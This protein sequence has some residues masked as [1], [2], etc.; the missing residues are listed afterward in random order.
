MTL[1]DHRTVTGVAVEPAIAHDYPLIADFLATTPGLAGRKFAA[2]SRDVAEQFDGVYPGSVVVVRGES[3]DVLGYAALHRPDGAE[4]EVLGDFVFGPSV[5]SATV[6]SVVGET[7]ER[8]HRVT[9][10]DAY[11]RVYV[12]ADQPAAIEALKRCGARLERQFIATRKPLLGEDPAALTAAHLDGL[13]IL[14]WP[15]VVSGGLTEQVRQLQF[16]TF[17]EHFGNM[18]K[19]P[20]RWEHHL[21]SRVFNPDFSIAAVDDGGVVVGYVLGSTYT[22]GTGADEER[23]AHTDYIGVRRDLRA[24]GTGELLLR[25]VWLAAL[26]RGFTVASLGTDIDN[27]SKAHELYRRLGYLAVRDQYAYRIDHDGSI[28]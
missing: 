16:D 27:A 14:S 15:E 22:E 9:G 19:T 28:R 12:G 20:K 21:R 4:P 6:E 7:V 2:D 11:L 17:S 25:K 3:A 13:T 10:P 23:S 18:S 24:R 8:F 26:R 1:I 5:A